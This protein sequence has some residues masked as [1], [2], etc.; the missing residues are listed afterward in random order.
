MLI[1]LLLLA[2]TPPAEKVNTEVCEPLDCGAAECGSVDDGCGGEVVC[3]SCEEPDFCNTEL[4]CE[5]PCTPLAAIFFDLGGTLVLERED[6]LFE[7]RPGARELLTTLRGQGLPVGTITN[8]EPTWGLPELA[9]LLVDPSLLD[10]F[11]VVLLSSQAQS[12]P[13][14][15]PEIFAEAV[16]MLPEP[17]PI[18]ETA[19]VTEE[20]GHIANAE[21]P[22]RGARAAGMI[23]V[24]L[25]D[26][27]PDPLADHTVATDALLSIATAP[28]VACIEAEEPAN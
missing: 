17:P 6:G 26:E 13:K 8:V 20:L 5:T 24:H 7:E 15:A 16:A 22:T 28:W 3:G 21:P 19:F 27:A 11:D 12:R 25:S 18:G 10:L 14:P 2:C 1:A 4:V 9:E 23:G